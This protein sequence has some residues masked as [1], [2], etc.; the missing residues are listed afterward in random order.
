MTTLGES[1]LVK[2]QMSL[3]FCATMN[4]EILYIG[5]HI[6]SFVFLHIIRSVQVLEFAKTSRQVSFAAIQAFIGDHP[7]NS[8]HDGKTFRV[9]KAIQF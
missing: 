2:R 9:P 1:Y 3:G 6:E 7:D 4:V 5:F 8:S